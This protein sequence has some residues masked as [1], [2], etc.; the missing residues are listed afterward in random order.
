MLREGVNLV[1]ADGII[2]QLNS[3]SRSAVQ[4]LGRSLR[5][6]FPVIHIFYYKDTIDEIYLKNSLPEFENFVV[7]S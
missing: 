6:Q 5:K 7:K 1:D 2:I 4:I 3:K